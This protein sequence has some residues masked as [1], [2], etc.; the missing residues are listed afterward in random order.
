MARTSSKK[1]DK[2]NEIDETTTKS[3]TTKKI[4]KVE[5]TAENNIED[6]KNILQDLKIVLTNLGVN[7]SELE[8]SLSPESANKKENKEIVDEGLKDSDTLLISETQSKV[9]LPYKI[10]DIEKILEEN[11]KYK[12]IQDVIDGEYTFPIDKYKNSSK[13][14]FKEAY[15]L[16]RKKEKASV[17]DS[18][19]LATE[20]I[21]NSSLNPAVITACNNLDQLDVYLDCLSSNELNK[22]NYFK[23]KYEIVPK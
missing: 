17:F 21:F 15:N 14:R 12:T 3:S 19:S 20:V 4:E 8:V 18:L 7:I 2:K 1:E 16:M 9:V 6:L 23:V 10:K 5:P 11:K 22:F 13:S